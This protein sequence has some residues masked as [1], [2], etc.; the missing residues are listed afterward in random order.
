MRGG[1]SERDEKGRVGWLAR[2]AGRRA[3]GSYPG[4]CLVAGLVVE[5]VGEDILDLRLFRCDK[6]VP[7]MLPTWLMLLEESSIVAEAFSCIKQS[8]TKGRRGKKGKLRT[9]RM[10]R[11]IAVDDTP[12]LGV[13]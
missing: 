12:S 9:A 10:S 11:S 6:N 2:S 7:G 3:E 1:E 5:L 4:L 8:S 13:A